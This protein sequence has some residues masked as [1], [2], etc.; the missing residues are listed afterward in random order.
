MRYS[1]STALKKE[2]PCCVEHSGQARLLDIMMGGSKSLKPNRTLRLY[3]VS[4]PGPI[5]SASVDPFRYSPAQLSLLATAPMSILDCSD[6]L[7]Q[8]RYGE[9]QQPPIGMHR[10]CVPATPPDEE[11]EDA[12]RFESFAMP[13]SWAQRLHRYSRTPPHTRRLAC[14]MGRRMLLGRVVESDEISFVLSY[15]RS[16]SSGL[17]VPPPWVEKRH[18][19]RRCM[20]G[21][22]GYMMMQG[23]NDHDRKIGNCSSEYLDVDLPTSVNILALADI[24]REASEDVLLSE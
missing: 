16:R 21:R 14:S 4:V 12:G 17:S 24:L 20:K 22:F 8:D 23:K 7:S 2:N 1:R 3:L 10:G 15:G 6:M 18:P 19:K 5:P 11:R 13:V 9:A